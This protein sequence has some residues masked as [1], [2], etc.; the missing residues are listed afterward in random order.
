ML[1]LQQCSMAVALLACSSVAMSELGGTFI[2]RTM[3]PLENQGNSAEISYKKHDGSDIVGRIAHRYNDRVLLYGDY[4]KV[5]DEVEDSNIKIDGS[6]FGAGLFYFLPDIGEGYDVAF[7][8]SYHKAEFDSDEFNFPLSGGNTALVT[9]EHNLTV[10]SAEL[11]ASPLEPI[12]D[13][14]LKWY[15]SAGVYRIQN[16]PTL[17]TV[18]GTG[19]VSGAL[20]KETDTE[21]A[22]SLGLVL[23][24][25][26]GEAYAGV[27]HDADNNVFG[28][29]LRYQFK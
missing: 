1:S 29:G 8:A 26:F 23:P 10:V 19:E 15:V 5:S 18:D 25:E 17:P 6:G 3:N 21:F 24:T 14:G 16:D 11:I 28:V 27:D 4:I 2:G 9:L 12:S 22:A 13:N 7:R 20:E